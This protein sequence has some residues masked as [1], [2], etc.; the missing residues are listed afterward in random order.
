MDYDEA[1]YN[2]GA[3]AYKTYEYSGRW[4]RRAA[5]IMS[6]FPDAKT[7]LDVGCARGF[8]LRGYVENGV[9]KD[10]VH[11]FDLSEWA[12]ANADPLIKDRVACCSVLD[13]VPDRQWHLVTVFDLLEHIPRVDLPKAVE[14]IESCSS[15]SLNVM[16][17]TEIAPWDTDKTHV[18]HMPLDEWLSMFSFRLLGSFPV[19]RAPHVTMA[20]L[21]RSEG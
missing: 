10:N 12:T 8:L 17:M 11:G 2:G 15:H 5:A 1:Y 18:S 13:F 4:K 19:P 9:P 7:F 14:V 3:G 6:K 16:L 21:A 20:S